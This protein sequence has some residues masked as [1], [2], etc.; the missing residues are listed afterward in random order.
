MADEADS[1]YPIQPCTT[2]NPTLGIL[3][4]S[5]YDALAPPPADRLSAIL[6]PERPTPILTPLRT[7]CLHV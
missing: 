5:T 6:R 1:H 4:T 2:H 3:A 7:Q